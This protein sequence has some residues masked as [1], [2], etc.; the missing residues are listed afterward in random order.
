M[1]T[2]GTIN[3]FAIIGGSG[4]SALCRLM[5]YVPTAPISVARVPKIMSQ[6]AQPVS[7]F[8]S[9][10]PIVSPGIAAAV[11]HGSTVRASDI[12]TCTA[13]LA[14]PARLDINVRAT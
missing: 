1:S 11:K 12:R 14:S 5:R 3:V 4:A 9:R 2:N 7:R 6:K 10:Q 8:E 13:P